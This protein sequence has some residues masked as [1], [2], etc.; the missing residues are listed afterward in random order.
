MA[1]SDEELIEN[2]FERLGSGVKFNDEESSAIISLFEDTL[3]GTLG[4]IAFYWWRAVE[5][6]FF[7]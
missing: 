5:L 6:T 1:E 2:I 4:P 7:F 3:E